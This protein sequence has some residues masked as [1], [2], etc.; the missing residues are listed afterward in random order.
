MRARGLH[1]AVEFTDDS[2]R[3]LFCVPVADWVAHPVLPAGRKTVWSSALAAVHHADF[4]RCA[5]EL[6]GSYAILVDDDLACGG[7]VVFDRSFI[8]E[9]RVRDSRTAF[10]AHSENDIKGKGDRLKSV[11]LPNNLIN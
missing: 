6:L 1:L 4:G 2:N 3:E 11:R 8:R 5:C 7:G 9:F 10:A